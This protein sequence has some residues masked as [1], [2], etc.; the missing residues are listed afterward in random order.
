MSR[1]HSVNL[2][3]PDKVVPIKPKYLAPNE[4]IQNYQPVKILFLLQ[5]NGRNERQVKRFLKSIYLSHHYYYI[6]VDKRQDYM[7]SEMLK[8]AEKVDNI[9][10]TEKRFSTIWGGAS[11]LQ[12]FQ[13]VIRDSLKIE[14]FKDWDY[15][16]NFS[17]SDFPILPIED[18]ERLIIAWVTLQSDIWPIRFYSNNG[19]SF[20]ASHGYNTGKF[21]H[22]QGF[23]FV[24]SECDNRMFR[25]GQREFPENLRIDG[26]SD[27]VGIHRGLADFSISNEELPKKLRKM[28]E[29]I[30][31]PLESF[32]HTLSFNS[33][34]CDNLIMSNLRL[35]N[36]YR[37][38][39]CRC[40]SLKPIVDWCGCSP[41]VFREDTRKKYELETAKA[42]PTYFGRKFDSM[43]D[44]E[45]IE[46]AERQSVGAE[47]I[48]KDHPAYHF[49]S[50]NIYK[51]GIDEE[52]IHFR[53][54]AN[55]ALKHSKTGATL[56]KISRIDAF[57]SSHGAQIE[58]VMVLKTSAGDHQFLIHRNSHV[59]FYH[60]APEVAGYIL[61]D[62]NYGTKFE[63]KEEICR[64]YMGFVT[65]VRNEC[66]LIGTIWHYRK[67]HSTSVSNGSPARESWNMARRAVLR[68]SSSIETDRSRSQKLMWK[69]TIPRSEDSSILWLSKRSE[70]VFT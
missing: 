58:I 53:S 50:A 29:S 19:K 66:H 41:L 11:L 7:Y 65:D 63:W 38:Q 23:E 56:E 10:I 45:S 43:V 61:R 51:D 8:V 54:L 27:W 1:I 47:R 34:F 14:K 35:T 26:G 17:E 5:L 20:L 36:W 69:L 30:L 44:I 25:I 67:T 24:F 70:F 13:Q 64:E 46:W 9:H 60:P 49:A 21:I 31:L 28:F 40:A 42:K 62:V 37:K 55:Y 4:T 52:K 33:K 18:F 57:R 6:H 48:Q 32:Y 68:S 2:E 59:Q 15:I 22:K 3:I 12:M 16:I 39:G